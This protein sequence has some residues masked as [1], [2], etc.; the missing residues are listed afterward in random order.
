MSSRWRFT[1]RLEDVPEDVGHYA[2][3]ASP[4]ISETEGRALGC[5]VSENMRKSLLILEVHVA[6]RVKNALYSWLPDEDGSAAAFL[7]GSTV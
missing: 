3:Y 5:G 1:E 4:L 2:L 7:R 6:D